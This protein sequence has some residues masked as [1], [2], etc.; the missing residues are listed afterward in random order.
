M[1]SLGDSATCLFDFM[2]LRDTGNTA[3]HTIQNQPTLQATSSRLNE[4]EDVA[5]QL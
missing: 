3:E 2:A 4:P 5:L 1:M